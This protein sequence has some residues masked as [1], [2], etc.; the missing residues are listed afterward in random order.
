M[1]VAKAF[2][3]VTKD[4]RWLG[5]I[6]FGALVS[7]LG[8][9]IFPVFLLTGYMVGITRNVMNREKRPLPE[10]DDWRLLFKDGFAIIICPNCPYTSFSI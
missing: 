10:W 9:F 6:G 4:E 8:V 3:Y 5:K 2:T 1:D 7:L